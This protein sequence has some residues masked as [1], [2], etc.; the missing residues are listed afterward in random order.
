MDDYSKL[1]FKNLLLR[2]VE[3]SSTYGVFI[4]I[5]QF[6]GF[7]LTPIYWHF[8]SPADYGIIAL[9]TVL[10]GVLAPIIII[11]LNGSVE[12]F[13]YEWKE[14]ERKKKLGVMWL[15]SIFIAL[16]FVLIIETT[17]N[18]IFPI[19]FKQVPYNP[20]FRIVLWTTF[21]SSFALI[22]FNI[23]RIT[24][25]MKMFGYLS[26]LSFL[27]NFITT[28]IFLSIIKLKIIGFLYGGLISAIVLSFIWIVWMY[29]RITL[30]I[31]VFSIKNE[32]VYALPSLPLSFIDSIGRNWDRYL[33]EKFLGLTQLGFYN[34]GNRF[35]I[36]YDKVNSALKTAW[37]PMI[38]K[39]FI[40]RNDIKKVL[41]R[42]SLFYFFL[43][44]IF[45]LSASLLAKEIMFWFGKDKFITAY[46]YVPFFV[47]IYLIKHF[48][49]A[50]GR[51]LDLIK[52]PQFNL[53]SEIPGWVLAI[54]L[55]YLWVPKYGAYGAIYAL[56]S[57]SMVRVGLY[58]A[59]AHFA[60]PRKFLT[61]ELL[62]LGILL[63]ISFFIG[64]Q[65]DVN[66]TILSFTIK[67]VVIFLY[68]FFGAIT[69]F[70]YKN[71]IDNIYI[72]KCKLLKQNTAFG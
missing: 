70:G 18:Y 28:I 9:T 5:V 34:V 61:W 21:F 3:N 36:Y 30:N 31:N 57:S 29:R 45:A 4:L 40:Q 2:F 38:Y 39:M 42:L 54:V 69:V 60:L 46:Q 12:R 65:I 20:Y 15:I 51:G 63:G 35:G 10:S 59:I 49:T 62:F 55:M 22:P 1:S 27:I 47:L 13:Y 50:W 52:K 33:L 41:P 6:G 68:T 48:G 7:F 37:F 17:A 44:T 53:L 16:M 14:E 64:Y 71:L 8:L 24:E 72:L 67:G 66:S 26:V 43:L 25:E 11:G 19:L 56:L 23:L 32:L 58:V